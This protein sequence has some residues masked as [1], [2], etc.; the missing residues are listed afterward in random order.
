MARCSYGAL[1]S[2]RIRQPRST[3][4]SLRS[5]QSAVQPHGEIL[6]QAGVQGG[7]LGLIIGR[8]RGERGGGVAARR[9]ACLANGDNG[10]SALVPGVLFSGALFPGVL[11]PGAS[12]VGPSGVVASWS[13]EC[14]DTSGQ[15]NDGEERDER[16]VEKHC[17]ECSMKAVLVFFVFRGILKNWGDTSCPFIRFRSCLEDGGEHQCTHSP[18]TKWR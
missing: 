2:N 4:P 15:G 7:E 14:G 13:C 8:Q 18:L 5:R 3:V 16:F 12:W 10:L 17:K 9:D 1:A 11:L 6:V